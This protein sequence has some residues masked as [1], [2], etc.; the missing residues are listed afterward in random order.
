MEEERVAR[1]HCACSSAD[2]SPGL[3]RSDG[4]DSDANATSTATVE[5]GTAGPMEE[6]AAADVDAN[7]N[8]AVP[9]ES[10]C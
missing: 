4:T 7:A 5:N 10:V 8:S 6:S 3:V 1:R 2:A 9:K